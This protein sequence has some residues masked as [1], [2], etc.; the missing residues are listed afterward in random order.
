MASVLAATSNASSSIHSDSDFD[1]ACRQN[2]LPACTEVNE[3][4]SFS[5]RTGQQSASVGTTDP[6]WTINGVPART[7]EHPNWSSNGRATW[8]SS[9]ASDQPDVPAGEQVYMTHIWFDQDPY[10]YD[11][12]R[13]SL[14]LGADNLIVSV[15]LNN[16]EIYSGNGGTHGFETFE[17]FVHDEDANWPWV[18]GCNELR[19]TTHNPN[20][21]GAMTLLGD[22]RAGCSRCLTERP[23][24]ER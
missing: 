1:R 7:V 5:L 3:T 11:F 20:G 22:V 17:R 6:I 15:H 13:T 23:P 9:G 21:P 14:T 24:Q 12:I 19:V 18:R 10:L 4:V 8:V 2:A 16:T